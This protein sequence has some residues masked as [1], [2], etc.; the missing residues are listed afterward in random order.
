MKKTPIVVLLVALATLAGCSKP[1]E[2]V[3]D[4]H[5]LLP[6]KAT[7]E[8][9]HAPGVQMALTKCNASSTEAARAANPWCGVAKKIMRCLDSGYDAYGGM[10]PTMASKP[11]PECPK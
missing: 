3:P 2:Q 10:K 6:A 1:G 11:T 5:T 8:A 7:L 4:Y 9:I